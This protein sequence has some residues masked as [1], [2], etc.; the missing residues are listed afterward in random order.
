MDLSSQRQAG[1][2]YGITDRLLNIL[3]VED[4]A[5]DV[6]LIVLTLEA[7]HISFRYDNAVSSTE[8]EHYLSI[9]RYDVVLSDYSL[10][11]FNGAQAFDI[12]KESGQEIPFILVTGSLGE[13]AAVEFIK[14][15]MTDY[16]LK[17]RLFR[18]PMVVA[19]ALEEFEL[20]RQQ[21][22]AISQIHRQARREAMVNKIV[23]AMRE[24][25]II[26]NVLQ[27]TVDQLHDILE[28]SRC[29]IFQPDCEEDSKVIIA[30]L[31]RSTEQHSDI[32]GLSSD[33][34]NYYQE[35]LIK[36]HSVFMHEMGELP[37][38]LHQQAI[39]DGVRS[40]MLMP[41]I[42]QNTYLGGICLQQCDQSR[43]WTEDEVAIV[44]TISDQC[45]IAIHQA[46]LYEQAQREIAE[47][48]RIEAR[49]RHDAFHDALTGLPNRIL[50]IDRLEHAL[51]LAKRRYDKSSWANSHR[52][53]VLFLDLDRFKVVNDSLGHGTGD[54]L[55]QKVAEHLQ[56]SVRRG[57]TIAR[58]GGDEFVILLEDLKSPSEAID[59][60]LR[61]HQQLKQPIVLGGQ[62]IF[63]TTSIGITLDS[64]RYTSSDQMLRDAD[65]AMY[66]AKRAGR[67]G[68]EIFDSSMHVVAV[69]QLH[70]ES[71]L[72]RAIDRDEFRV[73]YQP[74]INLDSRQI[75]GFEALIR[76]QH[77]DRGMIEPGEFIPVAEEAG[78]IADIDLWVM[79]QAVQ[80]MQLW[81]QEFPELSHLKVSV[82]LSGI[83]FSNG[84]LISR[85]DQ[86]LQDT[87]ISGSK[88]KIEITEGVLINNAEFAAQIL[89]QLRDRGIQV[90]LDD[91][92]TRYSS[93]N[94]LHRFPISCLKID[95]T[96]IT[97]LETDTYKREIVK[98]IVSLALNLQI[99]VVA[100]GVESTSQLTFLQSIHCQL[101]QGYIFSPPLNRRSATELLRSNSLL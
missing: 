23:Q 78:L 14:A 98:A 54:Q 92:G 25:L 75:L 52:F 15:G 61:I 82:N 20:R 68:Y 88:L 18:L 90:C 84:E 70:L 41:L 55:L 46:R 87:G 80:Q 50:F 60:T 32:L 33:L 28:V 45:A 21:Q 16:V 7:D 62:E 17:D 53:A 1:D 29:C 93:L 40:T 64:E 3:I 47:R 76:W 10:A 97:S 13:E 49:L 30:Y 8:A 2:G 81:Q 71:D 24:T 95:R 11:Q 39:A 67:A 42:Y 5:E 43:V 99:T 101:G 69:Q 27:T 73:H 74:I 51:Q 96:F 94:Y 12:L 38:A 63:I 26:E 6:E 44:K 22:Q 65:I 9:D 86:V 89:E 57:D 58:L 37:E 48:E 4:V 79:S 56:V 35:S 91:F 66:H 72:Q 100:E 83:H 31:N 59:V 34:F 36:S 19:R 85:I 77:P